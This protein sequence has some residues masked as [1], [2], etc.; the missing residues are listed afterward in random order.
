[1]K[2]DR[3]R[4]LGLAGCLRLLT[5]FEGAIDGCPSRD[6]SRRRRLG[7]GEVP[8]AQSGLTCAGAFGIALVAV[9]LLARLAT[10]ARLFFVLGC[11]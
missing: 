10:L 5:H 8:I 6:R 4:V 1:L 3:L 11:K 2:A 9:I 7:R